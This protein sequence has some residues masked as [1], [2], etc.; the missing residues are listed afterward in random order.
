MIHS[1]DDEALRALA[2]L[3]YHED[4]KTVR[5]WLE[6]VREDLSKRNDYQRD[7]VLLRHGQGAAMLLREFFSIQ[8]TAEDV[9]NKLR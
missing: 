8:D 3:S 7:E 9:L 2:R 4:Y 1:P 5:G 6:S